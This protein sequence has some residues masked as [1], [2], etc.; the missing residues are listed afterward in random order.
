MLRD[1]VDRCKAAVAFVQS[2]ATGGA[3]G[4]HASRPAGAHPLAKQDMMARRPP[5]RGEP[6]SD[7]QG[8]APSALLKAYREAAEAD[9]GDERRRRSFVI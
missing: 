3:S 5:K 6:H 4:K 1:L 7:F 9:Q 2:V 8:E